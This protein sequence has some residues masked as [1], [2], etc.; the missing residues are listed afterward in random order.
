MCH[1]SVKKIFLLLPF[2]K[3]LVMNNP[4]YILD[5]RLAASDRSRFLGFIL[6]LFAALLSLF[7]SGF[8]TVII[9]NVFN[10]DIFSIWNNLALNYTYSTLFG[11]LML[12]YFLLE[13]SFGRTMG[14]LIMGTV[15]V[16]KNGLKPGLSSI[17]IRTLSRLIPF[18]MFSFLGASGRIW[19]D[20]L[21]RTYVVERA[22]LEKEIKIF[23]GLNLIGE[24]EVD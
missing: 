8:I 10:W 23:Y 2:F 5:E 11:F 18:D 12:N 3:L 13:W 14:K 17:F 24:R 21:S 4:L 19:H 1:V 16:T 9:G 7:V 20:S 15:V 22:A 6:D